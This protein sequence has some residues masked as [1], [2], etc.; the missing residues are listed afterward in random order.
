MGQKVSPTGF[1]IGITEPWRS[2]WYAS[3]KKDYARFLLEDQ[4]IRKFV[5]KQYA[6]SNI[7]YIEV[8]RT[9]ERINIVLHT[10]KAG[11]IIGKKGVTVDKIKS[12]LEQFIANTQKSKIGVNVEIKEVKRPEVDAQLI[13]ENIAEQMEKRA[14]YRRVMKKAMDTAIEN[15]VLGVKVQ[16]SGRLSGAEIART[17]AAVLGKVP[18]QTLVA[19]VQYGFAEAQTT[20]GLIGIKSWVYHGKY[21]EEV[22]NDVP[23]AQK[24][25]VQK[26]PKR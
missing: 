7:P 2:R 22:T 12:S 11:L 5:K 19:H 10:A 23:D 25:K 6:F 20:Y 4:R 16:I 18:L 13:A 21:G 26:S 9:R 15:G 8:E 14:N 3:Q 17:E 1:R 24:G